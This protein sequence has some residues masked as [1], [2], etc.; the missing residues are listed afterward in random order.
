MAWTEVI[1]RSEGKEHGEA[2]RAS[3]SGVRHRGEEGR[4]V[5]TLD[6]FAFWLGWRKPNRDLKREGTK[7]SKDVPRQR[8]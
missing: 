1:E 6:A 2:R 3:L 8:K 5:I 7:Q 4:G